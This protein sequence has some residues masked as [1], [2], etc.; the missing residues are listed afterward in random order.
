MTL[1]V[2]T[3]IDYNAVDFRHFILKECYITIATSIVGFTFL[4]LIIYYILIPMI[5]HPYFKHIKS[6][7][8]LHWKISDATVSAIHTSIIIGLCI[9][10]PEVLISCVT[11][12]IVHESTSS[13]ERI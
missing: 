12:E 9:L 13:T 1:D 6:N 5:V 8:I 10:H 4:Y 11:S 7:C 3:D 2:D